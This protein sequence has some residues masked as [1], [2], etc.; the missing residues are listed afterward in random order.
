MATKSDMKRFLLLIIICIFHSQFAIAQTPQERIVQMREQYK[1]EKIS[2]HTDKSY[3]LAGDTIWLKAYV[4]ADDHPSIE[5]SKMTIS[6][7][8]DSNKT[9]IKLILPVIYSSA[10]GSMQLPNELRGGTYSLQAYTD[11]MA[12]RDKENFYNRSMEIANLA[13]PVVTKEITLVP[14]VQF[15]AESGSIIEGI[16]NSIAF[17]C[18]DQFGYPLNGKGIIMDEEGNDIHSFEAS[19]NGMGKIRIK[20]VDDH[21]Y[22]AKI[23]FDNGMVQSFALPATK[24]VGVGFETSIS[25]NEIITEIN[26]TKIFNETWRPAYMLISENNILIAKNDLPS[27]DLLTVKIPTSQLFSG[28]LKVTLFTA[29]NQ[30]LVERIFFINN[31]NHSSDANFKIIKKSLEPGSKQTYDLSVNDTLNTNLSIAVVDVAYDSTSSSYNN[32]MSDLLLTEEL[33]GYVYNPAQYFYKN[34]L[35]TKRNVDLVMMTNGWRRYNWE[36][37]MKGYLPNFPS[38]KKKYISFAGD[39]L[40]KKTNK[41]IDGGTLTTI[42]KNK[43]EILGNI[44]IP[45]DSTGKFALNDIIA[46]DTISIIVLGIYNKYQKKIEVNDL[47]MKITSMP[48]S[49]G[50]TVSPLVTLKNRSVFKI[51]DDRLKYYNDLGLNKVVTLASVKVEANKR[52]ENTTAVNDKYTRGS[53]FSS[54]EV[55]SYDFISE[56][57]TGNTTQNLFSYAVGRFTGITVGRSGGQ[58]FFIFR[59]SLSLG[60]GSQPMT[61]VVDNVESPAS[62]LKTIPISDIALVKIYSANLLFSTQPGGIMAV[63]TKRGDDRNIIGTPSDKMT[64]NIEGYSPVKEFYSPD[65]LAMEKSRI[66][67]KPDNRSTIYWNPMVR[68]NDETRNLTLSFYNSDKAKKHRVIIQG[69]NSAGKL[70]YL[71]KIIE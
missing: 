25:M 3:Y 35:I 69:F 28:I 6:L 47:Q 55:R 70:F 1:L 56:P 44:N 21:N 16:Y 68:L 20:P 23:T 5:S 51:P 8:N 62:V 57:N 43:K 67:K 59:N 11:H 38:V 42:F 49:A 4:M 65:D 34:D 14:T 63:F 27:K 7:I 40:D 12:V 54:G 48:I 61:I 66:D 31:N 22:N 15:F 60:S 41:P 29:A 50:L 52:W 26:S 45:I 33:K 30:P 17:K 10:V 71:E 36:K 53:L 19:H 9:V 2:I 46:S 64:L 58:E 37:I 13:A 18:T 24:A 39:I 32:I